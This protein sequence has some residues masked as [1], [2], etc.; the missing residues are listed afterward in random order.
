M[1]AVLAIA[2]YMASENDIERLWDDYSRARHASWE[3]PPNVDAELLSV[4]LM[5]FGV[6]PVPGNDDFSYLWPSHWASE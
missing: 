4:L 6:E 5:G 2:G 1:R 3:T